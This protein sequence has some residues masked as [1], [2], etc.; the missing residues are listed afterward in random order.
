MALKKG[1]IYTLMFLWLWLYCL[2]VCKEYANTGYTTN[3]HHRI[4][5]G[6]A[7]ASIVL[8]LG[9]TA[10]FDAFTSTI[11]IIFGMAFGLRNCL[12]E[13]RPIRWEA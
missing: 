3:R 9:I 8:A 4:A 10:F 7:L 6:A 1:L 12:L 13:K 11:W 5:I 2:K